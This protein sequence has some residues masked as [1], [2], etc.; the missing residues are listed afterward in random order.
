MCRVNSSTVFF[1]CRKRKGLPA[2]V[3]CGSRHTAVYHTV[4]WSSCSCSQV[5]SGRIQLVD[6]DS[7]STSVVPFHNSAT[8]SCISNFSDNYEIAFDQ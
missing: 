5:H 8:R 3:H 6:V 1:G 4:P 2:C 7:I